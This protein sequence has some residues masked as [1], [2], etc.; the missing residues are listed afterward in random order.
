VASFVIDGEAVILRDDGMADFDVLHPRR[1]DPDVRLVAF[2]L[3]S[4]RAV[5]TP[6]LPGI[7]HAEG[8]T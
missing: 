1:Q 3:L 8:K 7:D 2:D 6:Y 5:T 4:G